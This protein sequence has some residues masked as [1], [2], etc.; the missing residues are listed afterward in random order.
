MTRLERHP[1]Q[2]F[3]SFFM[4]GF[5]GGKTYLRKKYL[6]P[7]REKNFNTQEKSSQEFT[8]SNSFKLCVY[9]FYVQNYGLGRNIKNKQNNS[10]QFQNK[11]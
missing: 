4:G 7:W 11:K 5:L 6:H 1:F 10:D 3:D 9:K 2:D 8:Q